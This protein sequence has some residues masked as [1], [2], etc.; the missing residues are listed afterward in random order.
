MLRFNSGAAQRTLANGEV[1]PVIFHRWIKCPEKMRLV[2]FFGLYE[3]EYA[4]D[5]TGGATLYAPIAIEAKEPNWSGPGNTDSA[6][7]I[8]EREQAAFLA[9]VRAAGGIG[10]F[11]TDAEQVAQALR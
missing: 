7:H 1:V 11:A 4:I 9:M 2:D 10:I 5:S 8:R 6:T 3:Y